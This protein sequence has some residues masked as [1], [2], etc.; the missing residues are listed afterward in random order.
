MTRRS[1]LGEFEQ[2]VL[3]AVLARG[4]ECSAIESDIAPSGHPR[5]HFTISSEGI[6]VLRDV[7]ATLNSFW[8]AAGEALAEG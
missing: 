4:N 1:G 5:R 3:L 8:D 6:R 2:L 7:R